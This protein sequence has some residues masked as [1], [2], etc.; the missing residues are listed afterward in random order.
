MTYIHAAK[1]TILPITLKRQ[2]NNTNLR[3][4]KIR[5]DLEKTTEF[6]TGKVTL[7]VPFKKLYGPIIAQINNNRSTD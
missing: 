1:R 3:L 6:S 4:H 2:Q 5:K 7:F